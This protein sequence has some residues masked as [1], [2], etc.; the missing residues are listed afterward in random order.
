MYDKYHLGGKTVYLARPVQ[1]RAENT[2]EPLN[3]EKSIRARLVEL[4]SLERLKFGKIREKSEAEAE[5]KRHN[6]KK[7]G[8]RWIAG[9]K[10]IDGQ[11]DVRT[12]L[13]VQQIAVGDASQ[14]GFSSSTPSGESIRSLLTLISTSKMHVSTLDVSTAFMNARLPPSTYVVVRMP[15]DVSLTDQHHTSTY[16]ILYQA[17]NGPRCA[18]RAWLNLAAQVVTSHGLTQCSSESCV[19][20]GTF[21]RNNFECQMALVIYVDD[22][23]VGTSRPDGAKYLKEAF[24]ESVE[25]IKITGELPVGKPG[26]VKFLGREIS[27]FSGSD[28]L[29]MR[30]PVDYLYECV[31]DLSPTPI[32]PKLDLDEKD[33]EVLTPESASRYRSILGR[34]AWW[35]QSNSHFLRFMSMLATGQATPSHKHE[36][37]LFRTL[38][39]IKSQL[40]LYQTCQS[41]PKY[42]IGESSSKTDLELYVEASWGT[43]SVSGYVIFWRGNM[44]KSVSRVQQSVALSACEAEL[45][46]TAQGCQETM[47]ITHL[48]SFLEGSQEKQI[49]SI[50]DFV[51]TNVEELPKGAFSIHTDSK[52]GLGFLSNDGFSRRARHLALAFAFIQ[53]LIYHKV[54]IIV[55]VSTKIQIADLLTKIVDREAFERLRS[56]LGYHEIC[57]PESWQIEKG[58]FKGKVSDIAVSE[59]EPLESFVPRVLASCTP[60]GSLDDQLALLEQKL[61]E[62]SS[63]VVMIEICTAFA[64]GFSSSH[65]QKYHGSRLF[66]IQVTRD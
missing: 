37:A 59:G 52:S 65:L 46:S 27:R 28:D 18:S 16:A 13:V 62:P 19:F 40:H 42:R 20:I 64:S 58:K 39:F 55:W 49:S 25:K 33:N 60:A 21:R 34:V 30:V 36:R 41:N 24:L 53:R 14:Q 48:I 51:N 29:H 50:K 66:V 15:A 1:V 11:P 61:K 47:G 44:V 31:K 32:P 45:V 54:L 6:V 63:W 17:L 9:E 5:G 22:L 23:L 56:L 38:R 57:Q 4:D 2:Y 43:L 8:T 35:G 7:I 12:R 26:T 10:E 3:V